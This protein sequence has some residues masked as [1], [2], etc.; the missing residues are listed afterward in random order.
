MLTWGRSLQ[1]FGSC[2]ILLE[3]RLTRCL[4]SVCFLDLP[5]HAT[6]GLM[7]DVGWSLSQWPSSE[8]LT[9]FLY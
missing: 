8:V 3:E 6:S 4:D 7:R 1:V 9:R 5:K 2:L